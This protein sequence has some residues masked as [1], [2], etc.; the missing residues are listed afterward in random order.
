MQSFLNLVTVHRTS[1]IGVSIHLSQARSV[2]SSH[3][4]TAVALREYTMNCLSYLFQRGIQGQ[5]VTLVRTNILALFSPHDTFSRPVLQIVFVCS[6]KHLHWS[7]LYLNTNR[8]LTWI[9]A[10]ARAF[11]SHGGQVTL[12]HWDASGS[13]MWLRPWL[14]WSAVPYYCTGGTEELGK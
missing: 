9:E 5:A 4:F 14:L 11:F 12:L 2:R 13:D 10:L 6:C 7:F 1:L 3:V 8:L